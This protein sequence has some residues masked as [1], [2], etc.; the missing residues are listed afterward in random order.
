ML[1]GK[2]HLTLYTLANNFL[3]CQ[4]NEEIKSGEVIRTTALL[5]EYKIMDNPEQ[6]SN[7]FR[8]IS[9]IL[10]ADRVNVYDN[11]FFVKDNDLIEFLP[12]LQVVLF[13]TED[14]PLHTEAI[15]GI[16]RSYVKSFRF[17]GSNPAVTSENRKFAE[18]LLDSGKL[19]LSLTT[20]ADN[21]NIFILNYAMR[22]REGDFDLFFEKIVQRGLKDD[23]NFV[24]TKVRDENWLS[25]FIK[26][27]S[28]HYA[29]R[30]FG[31]LQLIIICNF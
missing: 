15:T 29:L 20:R 18:A 6:K 1:T 22:M 17:P 16:F 21:K 9:A 5:N 24:N 10:L 8:I 11:I 2:F 12:S 19:N 23:P 7:T 3:S 14:C 30:F 26:I 25:G 31:Q 4:I 13:G 28:K 27:L